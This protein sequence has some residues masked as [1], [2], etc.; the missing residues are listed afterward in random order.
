M[1]VT[2]DARPWCAVYREHYLD[3]ASCAWLVCSTVSPPSPV[4][5]ALLHPAA[6]QPL[7]LPLQGRLRPRMSRHNPAEE[8]ALM[9]PL[10]LQ[11]ATLAQTESAL[12]R[13]RSTARPAR[14]P[15]RHP[16]RLQSGL[17]GMNKRRPEAF[18]LQVA[19]G[20]RAPIFKAPV[21]PP[22]FSAS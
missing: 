15:M 17:S 18:L 21:H 16:S 10:A 2:D 8:E 12:P 13:A 5:P 7:A 1:R 14:G 11:G 4:P 6:A 3:R 22:W 20:T 9:L 19:L